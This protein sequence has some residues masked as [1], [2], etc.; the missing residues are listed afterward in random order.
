MSPPRL[1]FCKEFGAP[2]FSGL[3]LLNLHLRWKSHDYLN[4]S[5]VTTPLQRDKNSLVPAQLQ[6]Y[7]AGSGFL[8]KQA[9]EVI[10]AR[11]HGKHRAGLVVGRDGWH[12]VLP[13]ASED[14]HRRS[15]SCCVPQLQQPPALWFSRALGDLSESMFCLHLKLGLLSCECWSRCVVW[16]WL[17]A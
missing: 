12:G 8:E 9:K 17:S 16:L 15:S 1:N 14:G 10:A 4:S 11:S 13:P 7:R 5:F 2:S 3:K 6:M